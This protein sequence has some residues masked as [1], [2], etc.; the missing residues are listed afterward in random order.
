MQP[1]T[2]SDDSLAVAPA[3]ILLVDDQ[4]DNLHAVSKMLDGLGQNLVRA[5]SGQQAF[6]R[7]TEV[8]FAVVLLS[9]QMK[10]PTGFAIAKQIR[11]RPRSKHT[12]VIFLT[13]YESPDF[14]V[15]EAYRLGAVDYL[16]KPLVPEIVRAKVS[17]F[18][19]LF[20]KTQQARLIERMDL[21][22]QALRE[23]SRRKDEFLAIL[24]HELRNPLAP[25]LT[26]VQI[27]RLSG[28]DP[29]TQTKAIDVLDRQV[30]HLSRLVDDLLDISR[31][32]RGKIQLK[33]TRIDLA[34]LARTTADD[35]RALFDQAG[36]LL[37]VEIPELPVW[38]H[39]DSIRLAQV[40]S[41]LLDNAR[42][43]T[44]PG[45]EV[46]LNIGADRNQERA[47]VRVSDT[48][49]GIEPKLLPHIFGIFS[50]ADQTLDRAQGGLGLGLALVKGLIEL[51]GGEIQA[52]SAGPGHG[53]EFT[54]WLPLEDEPAALVEPPAPPELAARRLRILIIEDHRDAADSLRLLLRL[55]GHKVRMV[56][57]G[58]EGVDVARSWRPDIVLCDIGLPGMDGYGVAA[59]LRRDPS[60]A[61]TVLIAITGYGQEEDRQRALQSGFNYHLTKPVA[62]ETLKALLR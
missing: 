29:N 38:V 27:L 51:H 11:S 1:M 35:R 3:N 2:S 6:E 40:V 46:T 49:I 36:K 28:T 53:A 59:E 44:E 61:E 21:E 20:Q 19:E 45:G 4:V 31:I 50:Q 26:S 24:A 30:K 37:K 8:D 7:V 58:S 42:K 23:A 43:F 39:G 57:N 22:R 18:V 33:P 32:T 60:L 62:P 17:V 41:N 52:A 5:T 34:Q 56:S 15:A 16:V 25:I 48:G 13:A 10:E 55:L 14:P 12:P 9:V 47:V 54:A